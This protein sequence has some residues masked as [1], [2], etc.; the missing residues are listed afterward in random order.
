MA[1]YAFDGTWNVRDGKDVLDTTRES[2]T[3]GERAAKRATVE[4]NVHRIGEFYDDGV[5]RAFPDGTRAGNVVYLEGVG[6]RFWQIGRVFGGAFG[7]GGR[8]RIRRMYR[9][10]M[11]QYHWGGGQNPEG[12]W[13]GDKVIDIVGFS[14]GSA[15]A[16]HFANLIDRYQI[17][18]PG[19]A[20]H[21]A[22]KRYP[23]LG[24]TF[25]H[26]KLTRRKQPPTTEADA[27]VGFL[28]LF[29]TVATFGWPLGP[30]RNASRFWDVWNIPLSVGRAFHAMALDERRKTFELVRPHMRIRG[31]GSDGEAQEK[32]SPRL[33]EVWFRGAHANV[34]GGYA[35]RGLSDIALGWMM[36]QA[37]WTWEKRNQEEP[38]A[39]REARQ[40]LEP[41][42][43][44]DADWS[45]TTRE[46]ITPN[47]GGSVGRPRKARRKV[48]WRKLEDGAKVH[49][50]VRLR[51]PNLVADH[52]NVNRPILQGLPDDVDFKYD[53]PHFFGD[54]TQDLAGELAQAAFSRIP[55]FPAEWCR[56]GSVGDG[57]LIYRGDRWLAQGTMLGRGE[58]SSRV[59]PKTD[60]ELVART[61]FQHAGDLK[62]QPQELA[63][64]L[65]SRD[66]PKGEHFW[67]FESDAGTDWNGVIAWIVEV[68]EVMWP[69]LPRGGRQEVL[70]GAF[71]LGGRRL[72]EPFEAAPPVVAE[73]PAG[74]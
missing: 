53:P 46:V 4:T 55:V 69:H 21:R 7:I 6:T 24:I 22:W 72:A 49:H 31:E 51:P 15:L 8:W 44:L 36:A 11:K 33:Y 19:G 32:D 39:H 62:R 60:F 2:L 35:D 18:D 47:P 64:A 9:R 59:L 23:G 67:G 41:Y 50:S 58:A 73:P 42:G 13:Q 65:A 48:P 26:P 71:D 40:A 14:R 30:I 5:E 70:L 25:R 29:D 38:K 54:T 52:Y 68:L 56:L 28:G 37:F 1:L 74:G 45:G 27:L 43:V 61:W 63:V 57:G 16:I 34:G 20:R 10:L 17:P 3:E 66:R 12:E